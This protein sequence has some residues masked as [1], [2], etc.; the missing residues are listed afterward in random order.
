MSKSTLKLEA[1]SPLNG[2][3]HDFGNVVVEE[4]VGKALVSIAEPQG[5]KTKL[6][7]AIKKSLGAE[8]P[9]IGK[10]VISKKGYQLLGIQSDMVFALFDHPGGI[11][12]TSI[13]A[14]LKDNAYCTDQSDAWVSIKVSGEGIYTALERICPLNLAPEAFEIGFVARTS[15]EHLGVV[16]L[17]DD[18]DSFVLMGA[19]SSAD[20]LL[21]AITVSVINTQ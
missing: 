2:Y 12:D 9:E 19:T 18:K 1:V 3:Y 10:S 21:H 8:W 16:I 11:A 13:K 20:D 14:M 7:T 6:R 4:I 5:I 15:M 17:K